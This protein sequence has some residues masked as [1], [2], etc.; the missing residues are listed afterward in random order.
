LDEDATL[1]LAW[2]LAE[3]GL[4]IPNIRSDSVSKSFGKCSM[5]FGLF[6]SQ[7]MILSTRVTGG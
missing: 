3:F 1:E 5:I 4:S 2:L 7:L 6:I